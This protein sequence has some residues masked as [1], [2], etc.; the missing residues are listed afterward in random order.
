MSFNSTNII[1][2]KYASTTDGLNKIKEKWHSIYASGK[3]N[4]VVSNFDKEINL[5]YD[6][7]LLNND[8]WYEYYDFDLDAYVDSLKQFYI[9]QINL[10]N[11]TY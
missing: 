8:F 11:K 4:D 5:I 6:E 2:T 1:I 7:V 9:K 10:I 3:I